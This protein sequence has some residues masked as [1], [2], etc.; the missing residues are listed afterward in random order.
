MCRV[1]SIAS[2][3]GGV[4]KTTT[5][6]N[7]GTALAKQGKKVLLV[8]SDPQGHLTLGLGF[9]KKQ[10]HTLKT[11]L[12]HIIEED[13]FD[14]YE[15]ILHHRENVDVLPANKTLGVM[16]TYLA[17]VLDGEQVLKEV[18]T[19]VKEVYDYVLIDC[20]PSLG[21]LSINAL[22]ASSSVLIPLE[23]ARY[24]ADGLVEMLRT[25]QVVRAKYNSELKVEG[26]LYNK[27][28]PR[29]NNTKL[30]KKMINM[31]YA[32]HLYIF[33]NSIP[34]TVR[35]EETANQGVSIL[36]TEPNSEYASCYLNLAL[37]VAAHE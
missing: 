6:I 4:G 13:E 2:L 10:S 33:K 7:L 32:D 34:R 25:V 3:K 37:E 30:Y 28:E 5:C 12:E 16:N 20:G 8:D 19:M 21:L 1:I 31:G 26:I 22:T 24:A 9:N 23:L 18:V 11:A 17:T 14:I 36:E 15:M 35:I 29:H 27:D